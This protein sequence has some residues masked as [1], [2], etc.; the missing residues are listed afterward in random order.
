MGKGK[1][2]RLEV[3]EW[4]GGPPSGAAVVETLPKKWEE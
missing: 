4:L 2:A 3:W 1:E